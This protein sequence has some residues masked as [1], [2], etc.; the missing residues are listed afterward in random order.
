M[1][2]APNGFNHYVDDTTEYHGFVPNFKNHN[3]KTAKSMFTASGHV[4]HRGL[5]SSSP[6]F[7]CYQNSHVSSSFGLKTSHMK[8]ES[9]FALGAAFFPVTNNPQFSQVSFTQTIRNRY[10][11]IFPTNHIPNIQNDIAHIQH[12]MDFS[13]NMLN[14]S[15]FH[16][17]AFLDKN[18][19]ILNPKPLNVIPDQNS[20]YRQHLDMFYLSS[21]HNHDLHVQQYGQSSRKCLKPTKPHETC[22]Y[23]YNHNKGKRSE[24][25]QYDGR[26]HS[27]PYEK[28]GPYTCPKCNGVFDTSQKFAAHMSSHYKNE[29]NEERDERYHARIK[30]KYRKLSNDIHGGSKKIK[31]EE[32]D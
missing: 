27:L 14:R 25:V 29:T 18:Y 26:T 8:R 6:S 28:Y 19:G 5:F 7:S 12:G 10:Y 24:D 17:P 15:T 1:S 30:N 16:P 2:S 4:N 31:L 13:T 23:Y 9:D 11:A 3:S 21:K 22:N 20:A 32:M